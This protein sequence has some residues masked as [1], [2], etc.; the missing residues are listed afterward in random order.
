MLQRQFV[1]RL[2]PPAPTSSTSQ[3]GQELTRFETEFTVAD[4]L[5]ESKHTKVFAAV[6]HIDRCIYAVKRITFSMDEIQPKQVMA[7][8]EVM[9]QCLHPN[10][11]RYNTSWIEFVLNIPGLDAEIQPEEIAQFQ[12]FIQMELCAKQNIV[13]ASR[14]LS[15]K[16]KVDALLDV[17]SGI[18]YLHDKAIIHMNIKPRN[19]LMSIDGIP[20]LCD[21]GKAISVIERCQSDD[22]KIDKFSAPEC[23]ERCTTKSDIYSFAL[24]ILCVL[25]EEE[26]DETI[27]EF[28][29]GNFSK[30]QDVPQDFLGLIKKCLS[31]DPNERPDITV[32]TDALRNASND[33]I[34]VD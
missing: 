7:E 34:D 22:S 17:S 20:K 21:F 10:I 24:V 29:S 16:Q 28:L 1:K 31:K 4:V 6:N 27:D 19:V 15:L 18:S 5:Y 8:A 9:Q 12:F 33:L 14:N 2:G 11:A 32:V 30:L 13:D 3:P 25:C 26:D 23:P